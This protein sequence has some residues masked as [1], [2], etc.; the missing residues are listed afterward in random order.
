MLADRQ[1]D[2]GRFLNYYN[3]Q[4]NEQGLACWQQVGTGAS[5]LYRRILRCV[6]LDGVLAACHVSTLVSSLQILRN[7]KIF[8]DPNSNFN[9]ISSATDGDLDAAYA[10][11]MAGQ[12]W[13]EPSYTER[14]I[15][16]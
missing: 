8:T 6:L 2:F 15:K 12:K 16:V 5:P 4:E 7:E 13:H 11:L 14:G 3:E 1:S 9:G 10:M